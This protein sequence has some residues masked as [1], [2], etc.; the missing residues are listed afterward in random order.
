M[1]IPLLFLA[2][3]FI[4][5]AAFGQTCKS[6]Q[7]DMLEW[8]LPQQGIVNGH[9]NVIYP[10]TG[11]FYWVK[12]SQGYP[13]DV[14]TFDSKYIYQ[15]ITEQ[16]WND[17]TTYK[18]FQKPLPWMPRCID[19]PVVPGKIASIPIDAT[20]TWF[21]IHTSCTSFTSHNLGYVVNEIW[22]P[23]K[24]AIGTLP[25]APTLTLSYRY[26]CDSHYS[27]CNYKET[28]ALQKG[29]GM[30][31]WTYYSL[32]NGQYV[33]VQQVAHST[34]TLSSVVPVHPCW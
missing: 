21:D 30:I 1:R 16:V 18:I 27:S 17:P 23:S 3:L 13:W 5:T 2:V 12:G 8:M 6:T 31:L 29:N 25:T 24:Q 28:F 14:D 20:Q 22:G 15:S 4:A 26:S 34:V 33:Q 32:Q 11:T 7:Y 10:A 9:Y 19:I